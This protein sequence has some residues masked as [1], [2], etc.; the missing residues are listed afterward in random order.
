MPPAA[1]GKGREG[2]PL[3]RVVPLSHSPQTPQP[4]SPFPNFLVTHSRVGQGKEVPYFYFNYLRTRLS[5]QKF[6]TLPRFQP[7]ISPCPESRPGNT[8]KFSPNALTAWALSAKIR[9]DCPRPVRAGASRPKICGR[10]SASPR[11]SPCSAHPTIKLRPRE[12][13]P[14]FQRP[15]AFGGSRAAPW[16]PRRGRRRHSPGSIPYGFSRNRSPGRTSG[17]VTRR[18]S[19]SAAP[20]RT[21]RTRC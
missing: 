1:G 19:P 18:M 6:S 12:A 10:R 7:V 14:G 17:L 13:A 20:S 2:N 3:R 16:S 8:L 4:L 5:V 11:Q 21:T 15:S 9:A